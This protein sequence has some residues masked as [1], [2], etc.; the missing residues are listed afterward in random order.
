VIVLLTVLMA[1][2]WASVQAQPNL[3][4]RADMALSY[5][6]SALNAA[7]DS[8]K[9][10]DFDKS[11][12]SLMEVQTAVDLAYES[13]TATGKDARRRSGP[14]KKAEKATRQLLRR[15]DGLHQTM[16]VVDQPTIDPIRQRVSEVH[17]K[18]L[19][20]IMGKK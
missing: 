16:S 4:K 14:F 7:R 20:G 10:S 17:D 12:A 13:L 6:E 8:Y 11:K 2:D 18:L 9:K 15:L 5:A 1:V 3:E 19:M